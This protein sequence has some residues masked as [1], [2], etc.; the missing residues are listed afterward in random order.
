ME[1]AMSYVSPDERK[2]HLKGAVWT[3][4]ENIDYLAAQGLIPTNQITGAKLHA[5]VVAAGMD[6]YF[7]QP[8]R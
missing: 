1:Y 2:L 3:A 8:R 6:A 4:D 5:R 7:A